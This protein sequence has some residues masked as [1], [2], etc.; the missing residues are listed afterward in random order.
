MLQRSNETIASTLVA[1]CFGLSLFLLLAV[2]RRFRELSRYEFD[3]RTSGGVIEFDSFD[4]SQEH[5][6]A[7]RLCSVGAKVTL[8]GVLIFGAMAF[9]YCS[10]LASVVTVAVAVVCHLIVGRRQKK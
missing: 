2:N 8:L 1:L 7:K 6:K 9:F 5:A 4:A 10:I 3:H